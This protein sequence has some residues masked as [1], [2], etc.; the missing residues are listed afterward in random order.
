MPLIRQK[1]NNDRMRQ[2]YAIVN[3]YRLYSGVKNFYSRLK[4]ELAKLDIKLL[5]CRTGEAGLAIQ[6]NG[7]V[8]SQLGPADF[9]VFLD[10]DRYAA[11][12]L[13]KM[14][15]RL[16]NSARSIE[17]CDDKMATYLALVN[18]G[19]PMPYTVTPPLDYVEQE[20]DEDYLSAIANQLGYPLIAKLNY[21]SLGNNVFL[22][23]NL[24]ELKEFD[25][26]HLR[27]PRL[28]QRFIVS[29]A[30]MDYRLIYVGG[31]FVAGMK[32]VNPF[33]FRSNVAQGGHGEKVDILDSYIKLGK[34]C[35][36]LLGLDYAGVDILIGQQG[37]PIVCEVNSNAFIE[38][39][40]KTTGI[41]VAKEYALYIKKT[42]Y[43]HR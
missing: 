19:I 27:L 8:T 36:D 22:L 33:D 40:E 34:R 17:L 29:S 20:N 2:G 16:F 21:G 1:E 14:G 7:K 30:G 3:Q 24:T 13:E 35:V 43:G 23:Q 15:Y 37:E 4:E 42:I 12:G 31:E 28:Y 10:K 9:I 25:K 26:Q 39:I 38:G 41:N 11:Y 5:L 18:Q 6:D 32:R